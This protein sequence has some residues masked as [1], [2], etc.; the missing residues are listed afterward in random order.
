[1]QLLKFANKSK[2][3][4]VCREMRLRHKPDAD[5]LEADWILLI[6]TSA[7][8]VRMGR[9]LFVSFLQIA[10]KSMAITFYSENENSIEFS[11]QW[12]INYFI[13]T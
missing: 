12:L 6:P 4:Q 5:H 3:T 7:K 8:A 13:T 1:M 2:I 11:C 10:K 9:A